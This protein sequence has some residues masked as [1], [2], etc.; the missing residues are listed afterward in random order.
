MQKNILE[1]AVNFARSS[2]PFFVIVVVIQETVSGLSW[3]E[4]VNIRRALM[5]SI[6]VQR[7]TRTST[8]DEESLDGPQSNT[9][10]GVI[11]VMLCGCE[12]SSH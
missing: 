10:Q 3:K 9:P 8:G 1:Y 11:L 12:L 4:E 7:P 2:E 5:A 6:Q